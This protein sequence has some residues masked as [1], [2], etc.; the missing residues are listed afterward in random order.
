[1]KQQVIKKSRE[2]PL[3]ERAE[4]GGVQ[5]GSWSTE[6]YCVWGVGGWGVCKDRSGEGK[7]KSREISGAGLRRQNS[8]LHNFAWDSLSFLEQGQNEP[9]WHV[10]K[11]NG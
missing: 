10:D 8:Q 5:K 11:E 1:M 2:I 4:K 3:R 9:T 7:A 6:T